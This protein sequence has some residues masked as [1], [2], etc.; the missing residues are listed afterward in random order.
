MRNS[1]KSQAPAI[2]QDM[3]KATRLE[4]DVKNLQVLVAEQQEQLEGP[5]S[6]S[7]NRDD[8][9]TIP[10]DCKI[11]GR[12]LRDLGSLHLLQKFIELGENDSNLDEFP[13]LKPVKLFRVYDMPTATAIAFIER[14][15]NASVGLSAAVAG[16]TPSFSLPQ[17]P[18][19]TQLPPIPN[20]AR[21]DTVERALWLKACLILE[22]CAKGVKPFVG[23]V[24]ERLH[25][26]VIE[27]VKVDVMRD[28]GACEEEDWNCSACG[29][30]DELNF[31]ENVAVALT[32][33]TID[34]NGVM[35]C[36]AAHELKANALRPCRLRNIPANFFP[37]F[38][39]VEVS[40]AL[41]LLVCAN[42]ASIYNSQSST[43]LLLH[44]SQPTPTAKHLTPFLVTRC[45]PPGDPFLAVVCYSR[46]GHTAQLVNSFRLQHQPANIGVNTQAESPELSFGFWS[47]QSDFKNCKHGLK[48]GHI[49]RF[50]FDEENILPPGIK[51]GCRYLVT[52]AAKPYSFNICGPILAPLTAESYSADN[53]P[54]VVIRRSPIGR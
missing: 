18:F 4:H 32:I 21:N 17:T 14:C 3:E 20:P 26:Q 24:M 43:F 25:K 51:S 53:A 10:D 9:V 50:D 49:L 2:R 8:T 52:D 19:S 54:L 13:Q 27:N 33:C 45:E 12:I 40:P 47:L 11:L 37:D 28:L 41:P 22:A 48:D 42:P 7:D 6:H 29:D 36:G 44:C 34:S 16:G 30:A 31:T 39:G 23:K 5:P 35:D 46:P 1:R 38:N 15:R